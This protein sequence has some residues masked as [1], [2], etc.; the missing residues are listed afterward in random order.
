MYHGASSTR[1]RSAHLPI[2]AAIDSIKWLDPVLHE[3]DV[4]PGVEQRK[5]HVPFYINM[6]HLELAQ[7]LKP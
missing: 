3:G 7:D 2:S 1:A 5:L 6:W 4:E